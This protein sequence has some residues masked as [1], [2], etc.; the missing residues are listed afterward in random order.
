M[1]RLADDA[2][3]TI[4]SSARAAVREAGAMALAHFRPGEKT[5]AEVSY[6]QGGSPVTEADLAV[7]AFLKQRLT[8]AAPGF[9]WLSEE[10]A[11]SPARLSSADLWIVDPIDG[12][13]AFA[14]GDE[15]WTVA[16]GLVSDGD[17]VAGFVYAPVRD[18]MY[19]ALPGSPAMLDGEPIRVAD[20]GRLEGARVGGPRGTLE[21]MQARTAFTIAPRIHSLA[22]RLVEVAAGRLDAAASSDNAHDWDLAAAHAILLAAGGTLQT[23]DGQAPRYNRASTVHRAILAGAPA[24]V[25][26]MAG[27]LQEGRGRRR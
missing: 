9:G 5:S 21:A 23:A 12:T 2:L 11:D 20:R 15:D 16:V 18:A 4:L 3:L 6:K 19:V 25:G 10:T 8:A 14:R 22:L 26:E 13:R 1:T 17:P 27:L 7:D 24:L